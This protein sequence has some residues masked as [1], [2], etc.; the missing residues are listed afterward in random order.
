MVGHP[1]RQKARDPM[2]AA[3]ELGNVGDTMGVSGVN[4]IESI[5]GGLQQL[6]PVLSRG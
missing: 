1:L 4:A 5:E 3:H 6:P 2:Y